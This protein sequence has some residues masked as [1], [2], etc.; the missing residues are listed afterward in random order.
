[1][2]KQLVNMDDEELMQ[3]WTDAAANLDVAKEK[4]KEFSDEYNRRQSEQAAQE[5]YDSMTEGERAALAQ[6]L[7]VQGIKSEESVNDNG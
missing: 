5:R 6:V 7:E 3:G 2:A 4:V 1:M